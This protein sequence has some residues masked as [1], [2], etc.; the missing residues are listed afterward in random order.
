[1]EEALRRSEERFR[2]VACATKDV[3][4]DWELKWKDMAQRDLLGTLRVS[5]ERDGTRYGGVERPASS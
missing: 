1:M 2:L 3:I 4:W 5:A